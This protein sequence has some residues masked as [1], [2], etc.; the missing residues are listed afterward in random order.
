MVAE[1]GTN[2]SVVGETGLLLYEEYKLVQ[3]KPILR[4]Y[5]AQDEIRQASDEEAQKFFARQIELSDI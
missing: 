4:P 2:N 1:T 3:E 5:V